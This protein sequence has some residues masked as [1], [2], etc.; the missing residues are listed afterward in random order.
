MKKCSKFKPLITYFIWLGCFLLIQ[1]I[2]EWIFP[3][4]HI[5]NNLG[6]QKRILFRIDFMEIITLIFC[7]SLN[8]FYTHEKIL[9][10]K[11]FYCSFLGDFLIIFYMIVFRMNLVRMH[12]PL[13]CLLTALLIACAEEFIMRGMLLPSILH[14]VHRKYAIWKAIFLSSFLFGLTHLMNIMHQSF[15]QTLLQ[16]IGTFFLGIIFAV[17]YLKSGNLLMPILLHGT[18]DACSIGISTSHTTAILNNHG[19]FE[20]IVIL[21]G[22]ASLFLLTI[23]SKKQQ[24]QISKRFD[25]Q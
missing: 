25:L 2:W 11:T 10:K 1:L 20:G 19:N 3:R 13:Y 21:L 7:V 16:I 15:H 12:A 5:G 23:I 9:F 6:L 14:N 8:H 22:L 24:K 4:F 18:V 17:I